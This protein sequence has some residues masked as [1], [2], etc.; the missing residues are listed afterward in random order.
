MC[1]LYAGR[2]EMKQLTGVSLRSTSCFCFVFNTN[3]HT[4]CVCVRALRQLVK[5]F[6]PIHSPEDPVLEG[7]VGS[8]GRRCVRTNKAPAEHTTSCQALPANE[9]VCMRV[10]VRVRACVC[11]LDGSREILAV[12]L[13]EPVPLWTSCSRNT[14]RSSLLCFFFVALRESQHPEEAA[15]T[16]LFLNKNQCFQFLRLRP[17]GLEDSRCGSN[18]SRSVRDQDKGQVQV[19]VLNMKLDG[20]R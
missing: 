7:V 4:K 19:V 18:T 3:T 10:R 20:G 17:A 2:N 8:G 12:G 13:D 5:R 1:L 9:P 15:V 16:L 14:I 11:V 6:Q